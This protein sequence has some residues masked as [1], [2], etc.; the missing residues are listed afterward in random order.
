MSGR[1][2]EKSREA[3]RRLCRAAAACLAEHG[4][5]G[6]STTRVVEAAGASR[7]A[8]QH[9]FPSK[10]DLMVATAEHLFEGALR[11]AVRFADGLEAG[12]VDL[13]AYVRFLF[14]D[15]FEGPGFPAVIE[16]MVAAR[17]EA[18]LRARI[19]PALARW[20]TTLDT[21]LEALFTAE[22]EDSVADL[23]TLT[24]CFLRGLA[25]REGWARDPA[26]SRRLLELWAAALGPRLRVRDKK[27]P[28]S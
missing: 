25:V 28:P 15:V 20:T 23:L 5:H 7:G 26:E 14:E 8:L 27:V 16:L 21:R 17:T 22:G 10:L 9:H 18:D 11:R 12:A 2:Q 1:Q 3:R 24:R 4:Y 13:E 19:A 6:T